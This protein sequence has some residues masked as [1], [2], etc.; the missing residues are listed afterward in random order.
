MEKIYYYE[1]IDCL[2]EILGDIKKCKKLVIKELSDGFETY[3][4]YE[5]FSSNVDYFNMILE[6]I[7]RF[8]EIRYNNYCE[9]IEEIEKLQNKIEDLNSF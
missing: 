8:D 3:K 2:I 1:D 5:N 6:N 9:R 7:K 4:E